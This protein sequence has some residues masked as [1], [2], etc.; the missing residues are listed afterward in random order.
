MKGYHQ[1]H[2]IILLQRNIILKKYTLQL[3]INL[4]WKQDT[5]KVKHTLVALQHDVTLNT[6]NES[7]IGF[8]GL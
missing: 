1:H 2:P 3:L 7:T 4:F 6:E 5:N 8:G